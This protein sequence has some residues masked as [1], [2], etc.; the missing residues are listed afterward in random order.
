MDFNPTPHLAAST[1]T[2]STFEREGKP[3]AH[4]TLSRAF[5]T[6]I[7]NLWDAVTNPDRIPRWATNV[8]G[9]LKLNGRYQIENNA[10]GTITTC[11]PRSHIGLTWEFAGDISWVEFHFSVQA[12]GGTR[13]SVTHIP[14][15]SPLG[16]VRT[17]SHRSR[18]GIGLSRTRSPYRIS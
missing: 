3:A 16:Y 15:V 5:D 11:E 4:V 6:P 12:S 18:M 13:L 1:R 10:S 8:T 17:R 7:E 9:D 14:L 2:V